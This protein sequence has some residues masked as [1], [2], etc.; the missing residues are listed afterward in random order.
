MK[1]FSPGM[2][3]SILLLF[4][5]LSVFIGSAG[6]T[7]ARAAELSMEQRSLEVKIKQAIEEMPVNPESQQR[8]IQTIRESGLAAIPYVV[9]YMDDHRKLPVKHIMVNIG[10]W[11]ISHFGPET[12]CAAL[13]YLIYEL[14]TD[15]S[16]LR[17]TL[18]SVQFDR[19]KYDEPDKKEVIKWREWCA[20]RWPDMSDTCWDGEIPKNKKEGGGEASHTPPVK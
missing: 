9:K 3:R 8:S 14:A 10:A 12:V 5:G 7:L 2:G 16:D 11:E 15:S 6:S 13:G 18:G 20:Q 17:K 1:V 4:F 19:S